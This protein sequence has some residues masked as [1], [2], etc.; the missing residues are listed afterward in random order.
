MI[1]GLDDKVPKVTK[2]TTEETTSFVRLDED[3]ANTKRKNEDE[4]SE[5][6]SKKV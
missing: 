2:T 4:G 5:S 3:R 6:K 1:A